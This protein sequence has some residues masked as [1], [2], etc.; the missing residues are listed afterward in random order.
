M[1]YVEPGQV[2]TLPGKGTLVLGYMQSCLRETINGGTVTVG[3]KQS[4]VRGGKVVVEQVECDGGRLRLTSKQT[5]KSAVLVLRVPPKA[6]ATA[7]PMLKLYGA[8][9]VLLV[10]AGSGAVTI[11][12][13]D[14]SSPDLT[15]EIRARFVDLAATQQALAPGGVYRATVGNRSIVFSIDAF[16]SPGSGP[17]IGRLIAF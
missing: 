14:Q 8:S 2:I 15:V 1:D 6:A 11:T 4:Q 16:A 9:P 12:R 17:I 10:T 3:R 5:G 13:L 7:R